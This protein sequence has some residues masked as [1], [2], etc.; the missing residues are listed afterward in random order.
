MIKLYGFP[1]SNYFNMVKLALLEKGLAFEEV[2]ARPSQEGAYKAKSPMGK[3][4]CIEVA[5]GFISETG[6]ILDYLEEQ[7]PGHLPQSA[8]AR[9][10]ARELMRVLELYIELPG[11]RHFGHVFFGGPKSDAAVEEVRPTVEKG[12]VALQQLMGKGEWLCGDQ[13]SL[14]D[15]YAYYTLGYAAIALKAVYG[16]DIVS[17][18]PG[19]GAM[20][21]RINARA[22]TQQ[23]DAAQQAAFA[24]MSA[25]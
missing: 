7:Q 20:L 16:W 21:E 3:V 2:A 25:K 11:R 15:I 17:E 14:V 19:L 12:L 24:A 10:K 18:V 4:P 22:T 23:V 8:F 5:E 13:F 1:V 6:V 9:A